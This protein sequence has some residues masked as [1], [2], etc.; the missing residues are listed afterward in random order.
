M[1]PFLDEVSEARAGSLDFYTFVRNAYLQR[2]RAE[3]N[4]RADETQ[5]ERTPS[6][7]DSE[8]YTVP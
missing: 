1:P 2:R 7:D 3:V 5:P 4:D 6:Y 8:L